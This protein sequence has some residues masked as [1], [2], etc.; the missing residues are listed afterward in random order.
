[1]ILGFFAY[2]V[3]LALFVVGLRHLGS[4]RTGAYFSSAPFFGAIL[5]VIILGTPVTPLLLIAAALMAWGIWMHLDERHDHVHSHEAM[6][7]AHMHTHDA[8]HQHAHAFPVA[9]GTRHAHPHHHEP[10][11]HS[12]SHVPD[13]HHLHK[14]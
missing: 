7:H 11:T 2:G 1:M 12:H 5:S 10:L 3:S 8:H 13:M 4:A 6:D 14:H 9:P